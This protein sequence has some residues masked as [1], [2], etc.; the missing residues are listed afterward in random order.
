MQNLQRCIVVDK[1]YVWHTRKD[2]IR[3]ICMGN[4]GPFAA[5]QVPTAEDFE[6]GLALI[7]SAFPADWEKKLLVDIT[8]PEKFEPIAPRD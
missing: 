7:E 2:W 3:F 1:D 4:R 8:M 5:E 6:N